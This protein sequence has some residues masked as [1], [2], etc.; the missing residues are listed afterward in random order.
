[1]HVN[2]VY[3]I[4]S[5]RRRILMVTFESCE[6]LKAYTLQREKRFSKDWLKED[7]MLRI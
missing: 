3:L 5:R 1:M 7:D 6:A 2:I 4:D